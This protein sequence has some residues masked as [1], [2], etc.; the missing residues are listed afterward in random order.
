MASYPN[1]VQFAPQQPYPYPSSYAEK[2][3]ARHAPHAA[4]RIACRTC[5]FQRPLAQ[6][7]FL[8]LFYKKE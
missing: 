4:L 7:F 5:L 6:A 2:S 3:N 8:L 1:G